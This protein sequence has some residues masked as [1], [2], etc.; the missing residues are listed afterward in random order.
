MATNTFDRKIEITDAESLKRLMDV[1]EETPEKSISEHP[2][3]VRE[4]ERGEE[5]LRRCLFRSKQ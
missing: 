4:R 5:L 1:M 3:S 2:F